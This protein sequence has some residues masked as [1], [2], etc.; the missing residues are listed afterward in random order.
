MLICVYGED[1]YRVSQKVAQVK[2][3]FRQKFDGI[4]MNLSEFSS[5]TPAGEVLS[6]IRSGGLLSPK[7]MVVIE[8]L[9]E[10]VK[11]P[12]V[13]VWQ[14]ALCHTDADAIVVL[15]ET[16]PAKKF[17][18]QPL[19]KV[20]KEAEDRHDYVFEVRSG[21]DLE[22][23]VTDEIHSRGGRIEPQA[24]R[25]LLARTLG[26]SWAL[27]QEVE[28]LVAYAGAES[29]TEQ[30]V[31]DLVQGSLEEQVFGFIDAVT[32][33]KSRE[34]FRLLAREREA[35][36]EDG[37]LQHMLLRHVRLL[38][39]ARGLLDQNPSVTKDEAATVLSAHPFVAQKA[40]SQARVYDA[41]SLVR[42]HDLL[43]EFDQKTK[44]GVDPGVAVEQILVAL[45]E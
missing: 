44:Q 39:G 6:A 21:R 41:S 34:A 38:L 43:F 18:T 32:R 15:R 25:A 45:T 30:M 14:D 33:G 24:L 17:E 26:D 27:A 13:K 35:G 28:K 3:S 42:V 20:L 9:I 5:K 40:L 37:Y 1:G 19:G 8:G 12:D 4:G 23:L 31:M 36:A 29:I 22:R 7:R 2:D 11:T 10:S 16:L